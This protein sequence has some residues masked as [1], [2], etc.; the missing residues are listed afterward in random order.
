[1][2]IYQFRRKRGGLVVQVS[3]K[4]VARFTIIRQMASRVLNGLGA[5]VESS[6]LLFSLL[7]L[8]AGVVARME[9]HYTGFPTPEV[10]WYREGVEIQPSRDFQ[11][12]HLYQKSYL[13]VPEV[14]LEDAGTFTVRAISPVGMAECRALLVVDGQSTFQ[15][16]SQ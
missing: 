13:V 12:T 1:M 8:L 16:R 4:S 5:A 2:S 3:F 15:R 14:F 6:R 10:H 7:Y 9:V 11:I